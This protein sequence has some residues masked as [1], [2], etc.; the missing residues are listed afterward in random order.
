MF[1]RM[2]LT[3]LLL[4]LGFGGLVNASFALSYWS[5][6]QRRCC[7]IAGLLIGGLGFYLACTLPA[8]EITRLLAGWAA[9]GTVVL[10]AAIALALVIPKR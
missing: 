5:R 6:F 8:N 3:Y 7:G 2:Y 10:I 9:A 4:L 1:M